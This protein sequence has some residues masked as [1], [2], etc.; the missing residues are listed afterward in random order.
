MSQDRERLAEENRS[1][2]IMLQQRGL[3]AP[4]PT[5][6]LDDN[7]SSP[8]VGPYMRS[9]SSAS[10]NGSGSYGLTSTSTQNT[11]YT[12]PSAS[13]TTAMQGTSPPGGI[14]P[15]QHAAGLYR[16]SPKSRSN[17][18][19]RNSGVDY[20]QAGIDFVL[21]YG[22]P[23]VLLPLLLP[24]PGNKK[25]VVKTLLAIPITYQARDRCPDRF[26]A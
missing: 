5:A 22:I 14:S 8:S 18:P 7:M 19:R 9:N 21:S 24:L 16:N 26:T 25:K 12:P 15:S 23:P 4:G 3:S 11:P 2:K 20:D 1:L 13:T 10:A 6:M 17:E